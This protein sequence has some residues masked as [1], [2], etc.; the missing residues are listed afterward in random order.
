M[1][2]YDYADH[3]RQQFT[4]EPDG[5]FAGDVF[6]SCFQ[7]DTPNTKVFP[8]G[9]TATFHACNVNNCEIPAGCTVGPNSINNQH[10]E[11]ND[12]EQ[13]ILNGAGNPVSPLHPEAFA[14]HALS[15]LPKDIPAAPVLKRIVQ[16]AAD[17]AG[18][19]QEIARK[20]EE[21]AK[22]QTDHG[23]PP[24]VAEIG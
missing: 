21:I 8:A 9:A 3:S 22:L 7:Q 6:G 18:A 14:E 12:G 11:Q 16:V 5:D 10:S 20:K 1:G 4:A 19:V 13:W 24:E 15:K 2:K 23:L 17:K